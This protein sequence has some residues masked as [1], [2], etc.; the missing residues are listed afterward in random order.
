ML[1]KTN[2]TPPLG[3]FQNIIVRKDIPEHLYFIYLS[4]GIG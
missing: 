2:K 3:S 4:K 1:Q